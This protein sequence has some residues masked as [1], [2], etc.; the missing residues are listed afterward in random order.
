MKQKTL[1]RQAA[2]NKLAS[3]E[4]LDTLLQVTSARGW[5]ALPKDANDTPPVPGA[6]LA[7]D[8]HWY[9]PDPARPGARIRVKAPRLGG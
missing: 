7:P 5:I 6:Q 9:L 3:P 8:G 1:F 2:L 4:E